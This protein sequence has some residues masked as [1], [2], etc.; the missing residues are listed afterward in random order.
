MPSEVPPAPTPSA[1]LETGPAFLFI[2]QPYA[3]AGKMQTAAR[4][5]GGEGMWGGTLTTRFPLA[6]HFNLLSSRNYSH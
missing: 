2:P 4:D 3:R 6:A 1:A 5:G